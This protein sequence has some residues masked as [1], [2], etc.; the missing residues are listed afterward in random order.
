M[1]ITDTLLLL[2]VFEIDWYVTDS[3]P[4]YMQYTLVSNE[5]C[6]LNWLI[7][8]KTN[9]YKCTS[10]LLT[11]TIPSP[12]PWIR[13]LPHNY[14]KNVNKDCYFPWVWHTSTK[15]WI[16][17]VICDDCQEYWLVFLQYILDLGWY[18]Q[19]LN[20]PWQS[21][22]LLLICLEETNDISVLPARSCS[23]PVAIHDTMNVTHALI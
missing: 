11:T 5:L 1:R 3:M 13:M 19:V 8:F 9:V 20:A 4:Q 14:W 21:D 17:F 6:H 2:A 18:V 7:F 10:S 22:A 15:V 12:W 23:Q 16:T